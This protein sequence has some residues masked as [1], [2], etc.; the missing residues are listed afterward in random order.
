V[1]AIREGR[2][3]QIEISDEGFDAS[4]TAW[5]AWRNGAMRRLALPAV[6]E[7]TTIVWSAGPSGFY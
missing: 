4:G 5:L 6:G 7:S 2:P 1:T 3:S